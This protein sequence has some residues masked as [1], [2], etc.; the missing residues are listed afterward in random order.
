MTPGRPAGEEHLDNHHHNR[1]RTLTDGGKGLSR[2][3][4]VRALEEV[5]QPCDEANARARAITWMV[6]AF[7]T[8]ESPILELANAKL[9]EGD[10]P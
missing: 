8:V 6:A 9:L 10:K 2:D 4:R 1:V 3:A 5:S 7:S